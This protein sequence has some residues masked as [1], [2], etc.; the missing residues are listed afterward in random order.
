MD[1]LDEI[2]L[3]ILQQPNTKDNPVC[4]TPLS[5][6]ELHQLCT[7][8]EEPIEPCSITSLLLGSFDPSSKK[9]TASKE[10]LLSDVRT[11]I[12]ALYVLFLYQRTHD[13]EF[14]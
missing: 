6:P 12:E 11:E 2:L 1:S 10:S 14:K 3:M 13:T 8:F 7:L 9:Q 5:N 4:L